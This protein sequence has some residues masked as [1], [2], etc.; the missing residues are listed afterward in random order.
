MARPL[1]SK[2]LDKEDPA[3]L[4]ARWKA[5]ERKAMRELRLAAGRNR[6][7]VHDKDGKLKEKW[8]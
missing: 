6:Q 1:G 7:W 3:I 8:V 5:R 2:T 4:R